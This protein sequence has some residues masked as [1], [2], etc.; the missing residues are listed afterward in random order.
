MYELAK[1]II[2]LTGADEA[3]LRFVPLQAGTTRQPQR[4]IFHRV[5]DISA[6]CAATGY[7]PVEEFTSRLVEIIEH[8]RRHFIKA[9]ESEIVTDDAAT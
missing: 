8:K 7:Q 6:V 3:S 2:T 5:P 9:I 4:E 1:K